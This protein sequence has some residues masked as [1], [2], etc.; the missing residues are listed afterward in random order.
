MYTADLQDEDLDASLPELIHTPSG[1]ATV[2][3]DM[4]ALLGMMPFLYI[5]ACTIVEYGL[6][7]WFNVWN[8]L[9]CSTYFLQASML[10]SI[11]Q[12]AHSK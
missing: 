12:H 2:A 10:P 6:R 3:C 8:L 4:L 7:R 11:C 9:D 1:A 5:E